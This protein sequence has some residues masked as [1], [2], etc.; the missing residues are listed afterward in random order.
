MGTIAKRVESCLGAFDSLL[1]ALA[2]SDGDSARGLS[3]PT[4]NDRLARFKLWAGNIGAHR[5]GRSSLDYRLRDA[6]HLHNQTIR[7]LEQLIKLLEDATSICI[8][9]T[10]PWDQEPQDSSELQFSDSDDEFPLDLGDQTELSQISSGITEM[11]DCLFRL[12]VSIRNPA[13][14][15]RFKRTTRVNLS[16]YEYFDISHVRE[17]IPTIPD[18][19]AERLGRAIT[20]R[21]EYFAYRESHHRRLAHGLEGADPDDDAAAAES[22]IASSI[23]NHLRLKGAGWAGQ[24]VIDEDKMS[25][26]AGTETT[27]DSMFAAGERG[28]IPPLPR[29]AHE[30]PFVCPFCRDMI[31]ATTTRAWTNHVLA[32]LRPYTCLSPDCPT[33]LEDYQSRRK[34]IQHVLH[35]HWKSWKCAL[36][37]GEVFDSA[38]TARDHIIS[39][40]PQD[41]EVPML[42]NAGETRMPAHTA[43]HCPLCRQQVA[44]LKEYARHVGRHQKE[45]SLFALPRL[46]TDADAEDATA[47]TV[48]DQET[49]TGGESNWVTEMEGQQASQNGSDGSQEQ[50]PTFRPLNSWESTGFGSLSRT[51]SLPPLQPIVTDL[52]GSTQEFME[53]E[54]PDLKR[55]FQY[56]LPSVFP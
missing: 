41:S 12:S 27:V 36:G 38:D 33:P 48:T 10:I 7:L 21:R 44:S 20:R 13:P 34:W 14:H 5:S 45:L 49:S 22:T 43:S 3:G 50:H 24:T 51:D 19:Y 31:S 46:D 47:G 2:T 55:E 25:E 11:L 29:D 54:S 15:D 35:N 16:H 4:A 1:K 9:E 37:C 53:N 39:H 6:S 56:Y 18:A 23:P 42:V 17:A 52:E 26:T 32:D 8:G 30:R 28:K 40:K